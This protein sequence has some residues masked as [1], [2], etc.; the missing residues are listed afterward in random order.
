MVPPVSQCTRV[1]VVSKNYRVF[2]VAHAAQFLES[3]VSNNL[4]RNVAS[5]SKVCCRVRWFVHVFLNI[6]DIT[7]GNSNP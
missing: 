6:L 3:R 7:F 2:W 1:I 4:A 5:G